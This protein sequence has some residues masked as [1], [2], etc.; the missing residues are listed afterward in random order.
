[1]K[2]ILLSILL[3]ISLSSC[4]HE[5][6][7]PINISDKKITSEF[8]KEKLYQWNIELS[9]LWLTEI[10]DLSK[11]MTWVLADEVTSIS[12]MS[13]QIT[14]IDWAKFLWFPNLKE[15]N[16]SFNQIKSTEWIWELKNLKLLYFVDL[17][18]N[19]LSDLSWLENLTQIKEL[20]LNFN[21]IENISVLKSLKNLTNLQLAHNKILDISDLS[22]LI[23]L[24]T[25]KVEF[26]QISNISAILKNKEM[27]L[28]LFTAKYNLLDEKITNKLYEI[29]IQNIEMLEWNTKIKITKEYSE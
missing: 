24:I 28:E 4:H 26:N 9:K 23:N 3:I 12:L 27:Q 22:N 21:E 2:K 11:L 20:I 14:E 25:L 19:W 10:P 13:N 16:F 17:W 18:S 29:N 5:N 8:L 1:M 7:N 15:I 6:K